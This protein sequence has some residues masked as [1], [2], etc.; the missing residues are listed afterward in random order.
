MLLTSYEHATRQSRTGM[1]MKEKFLGKGAARLG[2]KKNQLRNK[3]KQPKTHRCHDVFN[4]AVAAVRA[5]CKQMN[6]RHPCKRVE[7]RVV[8]TLPRGVK[9]VGGPAP[10][11][12]QEE[13]ELEEYNRRDPLIGKMVKHIKSLNRKIATDKQWIAK[14]Q[15]LIRSYQRKVGKV[16]SGIR[17][18]S[19]G[20]VALKKA[21]TNR[22]KQ[23]A[24]AIL[25]AKLHKVSSKLQKVNEKTQQVVASSQSL[26]S[27]KQRLRSSVTAIA[28]EMSQLRRANFNVPR[29]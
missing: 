4:A 8:N 23:N 20:V 25:M 21:L 1:W 27:V 5:D 6:Q 7:A 22:L 28:N 11:P 16:A 2:A 19:R 13:R 12:N 24:R 29:V 3:C 9:Y 10:P 17:R 26:Q 14:V 18:E 15:A